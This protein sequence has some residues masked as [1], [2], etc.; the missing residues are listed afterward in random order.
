MTSIS[1]ESGKEHWGKCHGDGKTPWELNPSRKE[2][3]K[4]L[5]WELAEAGLIRDKF[6]REKCRGY[7]VG[8][9]DKGN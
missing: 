4:R 9:L 3:M 8:Y 1:T 5:G 6:R 7:H 2:V